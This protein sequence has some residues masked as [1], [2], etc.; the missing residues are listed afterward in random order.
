M[1][2]IKL[3]STE[4]YKITEYKLDIDKLV[5]QKKI[6]EMVKN[7]KNFVEKKENEKSIKNDQITF[8]YKATIDGKS[9]EGNEGKG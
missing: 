2:E 9:F 6:D 4:K 8:N 1:P 7:Y 5:V 3:T